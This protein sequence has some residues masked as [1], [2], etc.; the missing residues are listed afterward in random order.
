[1]QPYRTPPPRQQEQD[2]APAEPGDVEVLWVVAIG[3][4]IPIVA[5]VVQH[6]TNG[7]GITIG[8]LLV[9]FATRELLAAYRRRARWGRDHAG[10]A[11]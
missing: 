3:G 7:A 11:R 4:S 6:D 2:A 1:M 5:A 8:L 10:R 9:L